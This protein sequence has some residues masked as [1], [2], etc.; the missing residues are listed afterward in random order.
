MSYKQNSDKLSVNPGLSFGTVRLAYSRLET[1]CRFGKP[2][3][4]LT[5][6]KTYP[7]NFSPYEAGWVPAGGCGGG[8]GDQ[9]G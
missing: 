3:T 1:K 5:I 2:A 8:E 4:I 9:G 6:Y 7:A